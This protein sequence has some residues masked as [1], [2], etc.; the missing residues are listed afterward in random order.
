LKETFLANDL[1]ATFI[2]A[3]VAMYADPSFVPDETAIPPY[4][5]EGS[6]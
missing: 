3:P 5:W 4:D 2:L 1:E 6:P